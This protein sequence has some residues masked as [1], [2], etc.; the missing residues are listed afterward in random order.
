[1]EKYRGHYQNDILSLLKEQQEILDMASEEIRFLVEK[2]SD[3]L[4]R[5]QTA[6]RALVRLMNELLFT[7]DD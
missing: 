1:V 4:D 6:S 2:Y 5:Y 7:W 3:L